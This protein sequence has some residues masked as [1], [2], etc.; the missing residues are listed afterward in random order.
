M[1]FHRILDFKMGWISILALFLFIY[2]MD[3][4]FNRTINYHMK[5]VIV[6][7]VI[8]FSLSFSQKAFTQSKKSSQMSGETSP[9]QVGSVFVNAGIGIGADYKGDNYGTGFWFKIAAEFGLWDAGPGVITL[10]PEIGW[11][12]FSYQ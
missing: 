9:M 1:V 7:L 4:I 6:P 3:R 11:L 5:K 10:G 8:L 2:V 12:I